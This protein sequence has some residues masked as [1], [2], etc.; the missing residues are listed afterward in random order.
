[1]WVQFPSPLLYA[2]VAQQA[3]HLFRNQEVADSVSVV[4]SVLLSPNEY[5][6]FCFAKLISLKRS[7][8]HKQLALV[9]SNNLGSIPRRSSLHHSYNG[10]ISA[11]RAEDVGSAPAWCFKKKDGG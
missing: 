6:M 4:G 2:Y 9:S 11:C 5:V 7:F 8:K 10:N 1:M 3:E